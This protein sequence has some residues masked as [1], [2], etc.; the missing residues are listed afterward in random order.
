MQHKHMRR[1]LFGL[2]IAAPA[3]AQ[4]GAIELFVGETLF[5]G[6]TRLSA[7]YLHE[8]GGGLRSGTRSVANP[9]DFQRSRDTLVLGATHGLQRGTDVT[10]LAPFLRTDATFGDGLGAVDTD[11]AA[12]GDMSL[13]LRQRVHHEVWERSAWSTS[14]LAGLQFPTGDDDERSNGRL[15]PPG[16]QAGSGSFDPYLGLA[17]TL[18][19]DRLRIDSNLLDLR[20]TQ[21]SQDF[22][23]GDVFSASLTAG[24]RVLMTRYP[25]PTVGVKAGL[26]Y[27]HEDR[28]RL[29]GV[30]LE[31]SGREE[32][33]FQ[34]GITY[35]PYPNWDL[36]LTLELPFYENFHGQQTE[37]DYRLLI[38]FGWRF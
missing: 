3:T 23:S 1:A 6:G 13:T 7:T 20:P 24:Y 17:S 19:L 21:G 34:A 38:G 25:G 26:R 9:N 4:Q 18:E 29:D 22:E 31:S 2:L 10:L 14:V 15:L 27:R 16:L 28:A 12:L 32:L 11:H 37:V 8:E 35:H 36:V 30:S 5:V 33:A